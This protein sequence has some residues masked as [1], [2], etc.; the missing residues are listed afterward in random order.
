MPGRPSLSTGLRP[1]CP[2]NVDHLEAGSGVI[3][4]YRDSGQFPF[5]KSG[6]VLNLKQAKKREG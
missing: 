3:P 1:V 2:M 4:V 6:A 5:G